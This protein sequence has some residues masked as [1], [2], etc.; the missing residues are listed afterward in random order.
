MRKLT[1][2]TLLMLIVA[3]LSSPALATTQAQA[4]QAIADATAARKKAG[5]AGGEWRDV[6][7][8]L[9]AAKRAAKK[10]DHDKAV[11]LANEAKF[12]SEAGYTQAMSQK[13]AG[14]EIPSYM[15]AFLQ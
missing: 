4:K 10:G 3:G 11:K 5:S 13:G 15:K 6:G 9:R 7:K 8:M 14:K 2:A 12:Q 1:F